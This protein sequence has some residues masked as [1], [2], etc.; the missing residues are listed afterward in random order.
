MVRKLDL[1][2]KKFIDYVETHVLWPQ[3]WTLQTKMAEDI[4]VNIADRKYL[5]LND[6]FEDILDTL[7]DRKETG[8]DFEEVSELVS[9]TKVIYYA[10]F[11]FDQLF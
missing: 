11:L 7:G 5:V 9:N 3:P 10:C 4:D 2:N 8:N 6:D 1:W